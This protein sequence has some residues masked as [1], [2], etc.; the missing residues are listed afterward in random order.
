MRHSS[1]TTVEAP[2]FHEPWL[3]R[4]KQGLKLRLRRWRRRFF[5]RPRFK[6]VVYA[7][8]FNE[9]HILREWVDHHLREGFEHI[10]LVDNGSSDNW[11]EVLREDIAA[12]RVTVREVGPGGA[13]D[14]HRRRNGEE[15]LDSAEWVCVQD[16]DEFT[17]AQGPKSVPSVL[18]SLPADVSQLA[19]PW[20]VF[21]TAGLV[22]QPASVVQGNT[23]SEDM[24]LRA[25][26]AD[27]ELPWH[28][29]SFV[30][31]RD[32]HQLRC[33]IHQVRGR[34]VLPLQPRVEVQDEF[35]IPNALADRLAEFEV[36][37][38]HYIHQSLDFYR[39]KM[40][41]RGY[42]LEQ[43]TGQSSYTMARFEAEERRLNAVENLTLASRPA[44]KL[45]CS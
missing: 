18:D 40:Q 17:F 8:M 22:Q 12:G 33:H 1:A 31:S 42:W 41:R 11:R 36:L 10:F 32:V 20:V 34:T 28:V 19:V 6:A 45:A 39:A 29:K 43:N 23:R 5:H 21:G 24:Q 35:F 15:A 14:L 3:L 13:V 27:S 37:Q 9:A 16:L 26:S 4:K 30:R 2:G 44:M 7:M 38:H 25:R